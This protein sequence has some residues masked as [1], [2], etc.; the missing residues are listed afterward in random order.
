MRLSIEVR[1][2]AFI[3][4]LLALA[5]VLYSGTAIAH[6]RSTSYSQWDLRERTAHVTL[7][8]LEIEATHLPWAATSGPERDA[9]LAEY[10]AGTLQLLAG[11]SPCP[12]TT[13][14][15]RLDTGAG[16]LAFEWRV[17]CPAEGLLQIRSDLLLDVAP[18]HLHFARLRV[19]GGPPMERLLSQSNRIWSLDTSTHDATSPQATG[20]SSLFEYV[21]L[22]IEHILTGYDHLAFVFALLLIGGSIGEIAKVVTGFTVAH[23][24]T[25]GLAVLGY[26]RPERAPIEALIG[27]SIA[28]VATENI[29][30]LGTRRATVPRLVG[31]ALAL[32]ALASHL[33]HGTVPALSFA[34]LALFVLCYFGLLARMTHTH[35]LRW[36][37][38]FL[39]GL[40]HGFGF[41]G[42]L[43]E[44]GLP[45]DRVLSALLGFNVGV[46]LGQLAVVAAV[47]PLL[48]WASRGRPAVYRAVVEAGSAAIVALGTFWFVSRA[49]G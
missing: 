17:A 41:A 7:R 1:H 29:W 11:D 27:L 18:S 9:R 45:P 10:F 34:G 43:E 13:A 3:A 5:A 30:L 21:V 47:W 40:I 33:G 37:I 23:S 38:A 2:Q 4:L 48:R 6:E 31:L 24:I 16:R 15:V 44:A 20:G 32:M 46:E 14:P 39:F 19:D 36:C 28:L 25:L 42:V 35:S 49:Y 8:M 26:V 22:G 12:V